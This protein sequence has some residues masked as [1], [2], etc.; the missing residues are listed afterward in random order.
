MNLHKHKERTH[1]AINDPDTKD[2]T[3]LMIQ[4][5][6][7]SKYEPWKGCPAHHAWTL[8]QPNEMTDAKMHPRVV[9]YIN[10]EK[11]P[12]AQISQINAPFTDVVVTRIN[13]PKED[14]LIIVNVYNPCNESLIPQLHEFLKHTKEKDRR[15]NFIVA[16]DFN[17]H[18][19]MWNPP[20]YL[21]H[22][23]A[24][25][26]LVNLANDL[27]L[28]LLTPPGTV[29]YPQNQDDNAQTH[30]GTA[31]DLTWASAALSQKLLKCQVAENHDQGSDHLPLETIISMEE[32][33]RNDDEP[34]LD[35]ARTDWEKFNSSLKERMPELNAKLNVS[36]PCK[37]DYS[38]QRL[39]KTLQKALRDSTP[40]KRKCPHSKRWWTKKLTGLRR[41]A[42]RAR[43]RFRRTRDPYRREV[44]R[45]EWRRRANSYTEEIRK[46]KEETWRNFVES[47]EGTSIWDVKKFLAGNTA[48][49]TIP[50]LND[51]NAETHQQIAEVLRKDF[52][53]DPPPA[54]L[55]DIPV[56]NNE[57][58]PREAKYSTTIT[59][60][61][62][63][64]A[65]TKVRP[66]KAPGSDGITNKVLQKALPEIENYLLALMQASM[67]LASFPKVLKHTT[68]GVLRKPAKPDYTKSKAY[69][70]IALEST[71]GKVF[72]SV[73]A[74]TLS[75]LT[76]RHGLLPKNHFGGR[77]GR[78]TEDALMIL[79]ENIYKAWKK[80]KV[81]SAIFLDVAGAFNYVHHSR[82]MHNL[83]QRGI[84]NSIAKWLES[85]LSNRTTQLKFN[86]Q[87]SEVINIPAGIPQGSP[88][89]PILYMYYNADLLDIDHIPNK[90]L[91]MGFIDDVVYGTTGRS[92]LANTRRLKQMLLKAEV[93]RL[94]HGAKFEESKYVLIHFTRNYRQNTKASITI[95]SNKITPS[96]D[97]KYLGIIFDKQLR[98]KSH[99]Q[100]A[101]KRGT[102]AAL[103]LSSI[104][105]TTW[106]ATHQQIRQLFES[107]VAARMDYG[108]VI[109]YRPLAN[110]E[111][112]H[113]VMAKKFTTVQRIGMTAVL[114]CYRT[115]PTVA[116]EVDS[117]I[118]PAWLRLQ[119]KSLSA[120]TRFKSLSHKHPIKSLIRDARANI[121]TG[122]KIVHA[123]NLENIFIQFPDIA[124][125]KIV[126]VRPAP[127]PPW[128]QPVT[129]RE[130][131]QD[132]TIANRPA[133]RTEPITKK[134][135][136][137]KIKKL[138]S[139][140]WE[141][142]YKKS[143]DKAKHFRKIVDREE[144]QRGTSFYKVF[145]KRKEATLV[146]QLRTG[147]CGLNSYLWRFKKVESELC[148]VCE[149]GQNETVEHYLLECKGYERARE[150]LKSI[151]GEE[152]MTVEVLL[153]E[154]KTVKDTVKFV[155]ETKRFRV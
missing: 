108:A 68:T 61:Q 119:T 40:T 65:V 6:Y 23:E 44:L 152:N 46:A 62:V 59:L 12:P 137:A 30:G 9:T 27:G 8:C 51:S 116:L 3:I 117:G 15:A 31:I 5:P 90:D 86:G 96:D 75:Y 43:N 133:R 120:F 67:D 140:I 73:I 17:C 45:E 69:R 2:F 97:A 35:I 74:E 39:I 28:T 106:G 113:T 14:P 111:M 155:I 148:E 122:R 24:A 142:E 132:A 37:L 147:H 50:T 63:Q 92:D 146:A 93:W 123:S 95:G 76:E 54:D 4:E 56:N 135:Q 52:F 110:K 7:W 41:K 16:G 145:K 33:P 91:A 130:P 127:H 104:G 83:R 125:Q 100:Y 21:R 13:M 42:N 36:T 99:I 48:P 60:T 19:P 124:K 10:K 131:T 103:A 77:P 150:K 25:D 55:S 121:R 29:T 94:K 115:T 22:D 47:A 11:V 82:L 151:V 81:Y 66:D 89:S 149:E 154:I 139:D 72:E 84:P 49:S 57:S 143:V 1:G 134:T 101:I 80:K 32:A 98:F 71:I 141:E 128:N 129:S 34:Q 114:G 136:R 78:S 126:K 26:E 144:S 138:A 153:G 79:T 87:S 53:P 107:T 88:L 102:S 112:Q 20:A 64:K 105:R 70:P 118:Q 18:H 109:W 85:F 58:Y 38:V